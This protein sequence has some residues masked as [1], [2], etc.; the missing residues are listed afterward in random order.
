MSYRHCSL[1]PVIIFLV[2]I[3]L[4]CL[5]AIVKEPTLAESFDR[6]KGE[7]GQPRTDQRLL[8]PLLSTTAP[9]YR[10]SLVTGSW[11][12]PIPLRIKV[13]YDNN[14]R[15]GFNYYRKSRKATIEVTQTGFDPDDLYIGVRYSPYYFQDF[16]Q[17]ERKR[18]T[19]T[20]VSGKDATYRGTLTFKKDGH[21][22]FTIEGT[23]PFTQ[24]PVSYSD[25]FII[26][27][28][29]PVM[30][31]TFDKEK[32]KGGYYPDAVTGTL[33]ITENN[34]D[35]NDV[36]VSI[37][38]KPPG[39]KDFKK[40][41]VSG[42]FTS[43]SV[44]SFSKQFPFTEEGVYK[45]DITYKDPAGRSA[46]PISEAFVI[47]RAAPVLN[48]QFDNDEVIEP[49]YY[50][51]IR[52]ATITVEESNFDPALVVIEQRAVRDG[53]EAK[54]PALSDWKS[55]G[56]IHTAEI[57]Y[58]AD[59]EYSLAV[60]C[61]DMAGRQAE[62]YAGEPFIIDVN[63]PAFTV[64]GIPAGAAGQ[65]AIAPVI[66]YRDPNLVPES[67]D[68]KLEGLRRGLVSDIRELLA[69]PTGGRVEYMEFTRDKEMDDLYT[70]TVNMTD[71]ANNTIAETIR[72]SVNRF[73][74]TYA[75]SDETKAL[76]GTY[77]KTT[78]DVSVT[79]TNVNELVT[80]R[81][82]LFKDNRSITLTEGDDYS[83]EWSGDESTFYQYAYRVFNKKFSEDGLYRLNFSSEDS[84]GNVSESSSALDG[85]DISFVVDNTAPIVSFLNLE[86]GKAYEAS[87]YD[88]AFAADD[89]VKLAS[90]MLYLDGER[91]REWNAS[92]IEELIAKKEDFHY[93]IMGG[94]DDARHLRV[95]CADAA[96]NQT[97]KE[98]S[99]FY[100]TT[101]WRIHMMNNDKIRIAVYAGAALAFLLAAFMVVFLLSRRAKKR[102]KLRQT[103]ESSRPAMPKGALPSSGDR[104]EPV[105]PPAVSVPMP[106][107][108]STVANPYVYRG[109]DVDFSLEM[110]EDVIRNDQPITNQLSMPSKDLPHGTEQPADPHDPSKLDFGDTTL[111]A[112]QQPNETTVLSERNPDETTILDNRQ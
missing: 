56:N 17:V 14:Q 81:V 47:D 21:Y 10:P 103:E 24:N 6:E 96:G 72:F 71:K 79:E 29:A 101:S 18:I 98:I 77:V 75:F 54:P 111:L 92:A 25:T 22:R 20:P 52:K 7:A 93:T 4:L 59:G 84:A 97:E 78:P 16:G 63:P 19:F 100:I 88:V 51:K 66:E 109:N 53:E 86:A 87:E 68:I 44:T 89:N 70:L 60:S 62:P 40:I 43:K 28:V 26:D 106:A 102:R 8:N 55:D 39:Q 46:A 32:E 49:N 13:T 33:L 36:K 41:S 80:R 42:S 2:V 95:V 31:L 15:Y 90:V 69:E 107:A 27:T 34:F 112:K 50:N 30:K 73:G 58:D 9:F 105:V 74:S 61:T 110:W 11:A 76:A 48:V 5:V 82:T 85:M 3:I 45:V 104:S 37:K 23:D 1:K 64:T 35:E 38:H 91:A 83:L 65:A 67:V 12:H 108:G 94:S 57:L 99:D